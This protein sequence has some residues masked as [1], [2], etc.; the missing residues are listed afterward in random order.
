MG[1][2]KDR[3]ERAM[4]THNL[5]PKT[6]TAYLYHVREYTKHYGIAPDKLGEEQAQAWLHEL[7]YT[8]KTSWSNVNQAYSAL[9]YFYRNVLQREWSVKKIP[10]PKTQ[11]KLPVVLSKA[12]VTAILNATD[13]LKHR[14]IL[15]TIYAAGLR[16]S[17][18]CH[19]RVKDIDSGRMMI[20]VEQ[21]KGR[22]D[23][24][25]LLSHRLLEQLRGYCRTYRLTRRFRGPLFFGRDH[26]K[27]MDTRTA[28][29]IFYR[30][31]DRAALRVIGGI[32]LLRHCF[33][34]HLMDAGVD[35]RTIQQLMGHRAVTTTM[36]YL[37]VTRAH[38]ANVK[39]PLDLIQF[40]DDGEKK[41]A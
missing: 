21:G 38:L 34:T 14:A 36:R 7:A 20:R 28:Q 32:H 4:Q 23:R 26:D 30:A 31:R 12:E 1:I 27:P 2:L 35:V 39:S 41:R 6:I 29:R 24:Y 10:R 3:M 13:N 18:A 8:R 15:T 17:E 5:S 22:K 11:K 37:Q 19:L 33:A 40:N 25:T 9:R 16:I